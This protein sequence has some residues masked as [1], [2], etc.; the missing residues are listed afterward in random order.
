VLIVGATIIATVVGLI[1]I[2]HFAARY[3]IVRG[4]AWALG[5]V[6][7]SLPSFFWAMLL[8]RSRAK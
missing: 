3:R 6:G 4:V 1:A 5:T 8:R 7:V 2:V